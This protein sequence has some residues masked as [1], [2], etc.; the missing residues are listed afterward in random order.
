MS[1]NDENAYI[2]KLELQQWCH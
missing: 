1:L 2:F